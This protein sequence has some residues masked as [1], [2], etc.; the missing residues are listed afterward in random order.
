MMLT[1]NVVGD[2]IVG[3]YGG[4]PFGV[5][6]SEQKYAQMK[7][8]E[9]KANAATSMDEL[10]TI[11]EDFELLTKEDYKELV[12][13][14]AG[15]QFLWVNNHTG[16]IYL[17]ING[18]VS[19]IAIPKAL[20]NRIIASVEKKI[21][22]LPLVKAWARYIRPIPGRPA[23]T[24]ER[25]S[26]F[27][28]YIDAD[29]TNAQFAGEL[30]KEF[31][32]APEVAAV[33]A[34]TKQVAITQEGL[35]VCYKVSKEILTRYELNEDED[36]VTKSRYTKSVDPDSGMVTYDEPK[37]VEERLFEPYVMGKGGDEFYCGDKPG[38]FIRVGMPHYLDSW[39]KVSSPG[40]KGLHCGGLKYIAGYQQEGTVTHNIFVDP[41]D[42]HTI[43]GL[44]YGNDGAMTV[45]RYFVHSSFAG[46]NKSIYHSSEYAKVTDAEYAKLIEEA[47]EASQQDVDKIA[48]E[49]EEKKNLL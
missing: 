14:S 18:K 22:V 39:D 48:A 31:G 11:L 34:T 19:S 21:D 46:V 1:I 42:I 49:L 45:K 2:N 44:G 23:Y 26:M 47:V 9:A 30:V 41:M 12:E 32:L 4:K 29:Y 27:A 13:H 20:V 10:K 3:S 16:K 43:G 35:L 5:Q 36:V 38:H 37:F 6:F 28:Q 15:G 40:N 17:A 8:L 33:R 25:G 24:A 7:D